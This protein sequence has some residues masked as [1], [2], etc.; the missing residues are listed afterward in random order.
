M[1]LLGVPVKTKER[2]CKV[3]MMLRMRDKLNVLKLKTDN[4][5]RFKLRYL[6]MKK[7]TFSGTVFV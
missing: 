2:T 7:M 1:L 4:Q 3:V 6:S 5:V